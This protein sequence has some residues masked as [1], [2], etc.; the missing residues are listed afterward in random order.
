MQRTSS[1][2]RAAK[3]LMD[4]ISASIGLLLS[5]PLLAVAALA[6]KVDSRGPVVFRQERVGRNGVHFE[7]LKLRTMVIDAEALRPQLE[8]LN[9]FAPPLFKIR[10]DPRLTRVGRVLRRWSIDEIPQFVN[11]L[12]GEMSVVGPR[13]ALP[14]EEGSWPADLRRRL[15][16]PPGIT[17]LWQVCG[18]PDASF[19]DYRR[20]DL[21]YVDNWSLRDDL[22]IVLKSVIVV[23]RGSSS[24]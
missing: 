7:M 13:P 12:R 3:R 9:E 16:V 20:L 17:G 6:I 5:A 1:T 4:L 2:R 21:Y 8:P 19:E 11:V 14:E 10:D 18:R 24:S 15:E 23:L 22:R